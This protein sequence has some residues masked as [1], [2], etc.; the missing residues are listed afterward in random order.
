MLDQR[1]PKDSL[2]D[3]AWTRASSH[4][5]WDIG[6]CNEDRTLT[7]MTSG[8][9]RCIHGKMEQYERGFVDVRIAG[10]KGKLHIGL[11]PQ[12]DGQMIVGRDWPPLY[13][14]LEEVRAEEIKRKRQPHRDGWIAEEDSASSGENGWVSFGTGAEG[15]YFR[16]AQEEDDELWKIR[17]T[18]VAR[19]EEETI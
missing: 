9:M 8:R 1:R 5:D 7:R 2:V 12:L 15:G 3:L 14:V 19:V 10:C 6:K 4:S 16:T 11:A 18:E 17:E 13:E